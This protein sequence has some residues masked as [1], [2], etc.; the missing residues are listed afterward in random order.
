MLV[1]Q[2]GK[3]MHRLEESSSVALSWHGDS[4]KY[5]SCCVWLW[6]HEPLCIVQSAAAALTVR[7]ALEHGLQP[8]R[9]FN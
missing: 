9:E 2:G 8:N 3:V 6:Q 1:L 4:I 5:C 7:P